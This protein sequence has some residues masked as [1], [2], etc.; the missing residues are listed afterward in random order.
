M[1]RE[2]EDNTLVMHE[3]LEAALGLAVLEVCDD[4]ALLHV[5]VAAEDV[6]DVWKCQG[7][8]GYRRRV[9]REDGG[10]GG[11]AGGCNGSGSCGR[12]GADALFLVAVVVAAVPMAVVVAVVVLRGGGGAAPG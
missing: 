8:F 7:V 12:R 10:G 2:G 9:E 1:R 6:E 5:Q 3:A 4:E 11:G